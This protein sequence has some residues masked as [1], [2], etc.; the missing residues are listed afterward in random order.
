MDN[1]PKFEIFEARQREFE[2]SHGTGNE[3]RP[4][5]EIFEARQR[6]FETSHGTGNEH[7]PKF[8]ILILGRGG[9]YK[10]ASISL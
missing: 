2:T 3:H 10:H 7:R 1:H 6:E 9:G 5:F 8:E 4:K